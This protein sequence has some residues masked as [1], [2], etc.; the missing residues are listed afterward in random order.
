MPNPRPTKRLTTV[1]SLAMAGKHSVE[2]LSRRLRK[3]AEEVRKVFDALIE[4]EEFYLVKTSKGIFLRKKQIRNPE[5]KKNPAKQAISYEKLSV[6]FRR[7]QIIDLAM[8]GKKFEEVFEEIFKSDSSKKTSFLRTLN[9]LIAL[10]FGK[11]KISL[12][13]LLESYE[14]YQRKMRFEKDQKSVR[15]RIEKQEKIEVQ[16]R[17]GNLDPLIKRF[18]EFKLNPRNEIRIKSALVKI[19]L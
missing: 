3:P 8:A 10:S 1:R 17:T 9:H 15:K 16:E 2:M 4:K 14:D 12:E 7:K 19:G 13:K 11:T 5:A 18:Y 6:A